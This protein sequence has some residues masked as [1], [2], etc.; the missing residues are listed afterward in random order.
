MTHRIY[1]GNLPYGTTE[2]DLRQLFAA[3]GGVRSVEIAR[4]SETHYPRGF[5]FVEMA[6]SAEAIAA[7][8]RLH[9]AAFGGKVLQVSE[10]PQLGNAPR[11][12]PTAPRLIRRR[13]AILP[14]RR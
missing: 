4:H 10:A 5:G 6:T 8:H 7:V 2:I 13:D 1:V 3:G 11:P 9:L 12:V 14:S